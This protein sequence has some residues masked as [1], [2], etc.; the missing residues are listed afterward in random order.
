MATD[1]VITIVGNLT[2]DPELRFTPA[3]AAVANVRVAVNQ[4]FFNKD[5]NQWDDRL[6]GYFTVNIWRDHAEN[7]AESLKKGNRVLVTGRLR[8]R[9]Y[10]D[11]EGQTRWVTEIEADEICP[12]LRWAVA[13]VKK[14]NRSG[15]GGG[16]GAE[17]GADS[18]FGGAPP[19][20]QLPDSSE[21]PF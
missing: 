11:K 8:S 10:E 16:G 3:G 18:S 13:D 5:T 19:P 21:V 9:S 4:R 7:V 20:V 2:D 1:N 12:S 15:G 17:R 6:D 14:M